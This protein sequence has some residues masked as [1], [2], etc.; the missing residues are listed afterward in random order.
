MART[1]YAT[2][3]GLIA[4]MGV[5][6]FLLG[7]VFTGFVIALYFVLFYYGNRNGNNGG[8]GAGSSCSPC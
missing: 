2:D 6:M 5:T 1:R 7:L 3:R 4:R 8:S